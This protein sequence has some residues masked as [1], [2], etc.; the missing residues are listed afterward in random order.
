MSEMIR[1]VD[2]YYTTTTD[3]PGEGTRLLTALKQAG[4][5]LLALHGFPSARKAQID[6]VPVDPAAFVAAA[7]TARIKLSKP[8]TAFLVEGDDRAGAVGDVMARLSAININVTAI[9]GVC[10]GMGR[11]GA[12]IWVKPRDVKKAAA[13][14]GAM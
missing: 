3:K 4:V 14:L 6:F 8:K 9:S 2:Y 12:I 5:G 11:Y 1:K 13:A 10:A 7:K